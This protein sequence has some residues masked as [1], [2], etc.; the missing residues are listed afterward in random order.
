[1]EFVDREPT[2]RGKVTFGFG[3]VTRV[4]GRGVIGLS[5]Q[6]FEDI[7]PAGGGQPISHR[8]YHSSYCVAC[9]FFLDWV[10]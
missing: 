9:R 4:G 6:G 8:F 5:D 2:K 7:N 1:M 10:D 3:G